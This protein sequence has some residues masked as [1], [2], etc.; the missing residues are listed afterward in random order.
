MKKRLLPISLMPM[1]AIALSGCFAFPIPSNET[2]GGH[3]A[4]GDKKV[5]SAFVPGKST[6]HEVLN[7]LGE[8][9]GN[10][11]DGEQIN[12]R[13]RKQHVKLLFMIVDDADTAKLYGTNKRL[14]IDFDENGVL[15]TQNILSEADWGAVS[16]Q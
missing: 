7:R 16:E 11:N 5:D 13:W 1:L 14:V 8:P 15:R 9:D 10:K 12:Y 6:R 2:T 3:L 4:L